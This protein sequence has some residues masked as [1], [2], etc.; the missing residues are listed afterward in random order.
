MSFFRSSAILEIYRITVLRTARHLSLP[1]VRSVYHPSSF[2]KINFNISLPST[3]RS[4]TY[5]PSFRFRD[6]NL[7][8]IIFPPH[9]PHANAQLILLDLTIRVTFGRLY[10]NK[11]PHYVVFFQSPVNTFLLSPNNFISITSLNI[12]HLILKWAIPVVCM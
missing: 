4:S 3:T 6:Q 7:L 1:W 8:C 5:S 2:L 10:N 9:V 12:L 11:A